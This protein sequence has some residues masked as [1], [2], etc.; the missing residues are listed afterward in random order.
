MRTATEIK[1]LIVDFGT[2]D[3]SVLAILLNGPRANPM[4]TPDKFQDL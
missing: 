2:K 3:D 1:N 4:V